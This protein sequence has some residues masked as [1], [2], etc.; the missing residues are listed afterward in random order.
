MANTEQLLADLDAPTRALIEGDLELL[1]EETGFTRWAQWSAASS[2]MGLAQIAEDLGLGIDFNED[3]ALMYRDMAEVA[4]ED[5]PVLGLAGALIGSTIDVAGGSLA[6]GAIRG[7]GKL[8]SSLGVQ[9]WNNLFTQGLAGGAIGGFLEPILTEDD[10]TARNIAYGTAFGGAIGGALAGASRLFRGPE[11]TP[12]PEQGLLALPAPE[13]PVALLPSP[14]V[15]T[16][17]I[18]FEPS[19]TG[20]PATAGGVVS[21]PQDASALPPIRVGAEAPV[22]PGEQL[23]LPKPPINFTA[24][25][26]QN[27]LAQVRKDLLYLTDS[28]PDPKTVR[29][30]QAKVR[31]SNGKIEAWKSQKPSKENDIKIRAEQKKIAKEQDVLNRNEIAKQA[32]LEVTRIDSGNISP[33]VLDRVANVV[34]KTVRSTGNAIPTRG[35]TPTRRTMEPTPPP[36][37]QT[38]EVLGR[39]IVGRRAEQGSTTGAQEVNPATAM[40]DQAE[41]EK[42]PFR[43]TQAK[44]AQGEV[45]GQGGRVFTNAEERRRKMYQNAEDVGR[46]YFFQPED[47]RGRDY[48]FENVQDAAAVLQRDIEEAITEGN[49]KDAGD[50]LVKTFNASRTKTLTPV[51]QLVASRVLAVASDNLNKLMPMIRKMSQQGELNTKEAVRLADDLQVT[52]ELMGLMRQLERIDEASRRNISNALKNYKLANKMQQKHQRQLMENKI[53]SDLFF[54][55]ACSG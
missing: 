52:K 7:L 50:W 38:T 34:K 51:E 1:K 6:G 17:R 36:N 8:T 33:L 9:G 10:S 4:S 40:V 26:S 15:A 5:N 27:A 49:F 42:V 35:T 25:D 13:R 18:G 44:E 20:K 54:G 43:S 39:T 32:R 46:Q 30:A 14:E 21:L 29:K 41:V 28:A 11:P 45:P 22:V 47:L 53:I 24:Q 3:E 12:P 2:I 48:N 19:P 31:A 16:P 37:V 23:A 55:V